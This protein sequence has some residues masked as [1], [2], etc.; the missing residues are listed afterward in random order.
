MSLPTVHESEMFPVPNGGNGRASQA[1]AQKSGMLTAFTRHKLLVFFMLVCGLGF[2]YLYFTRTPVLYESSTQILM[3]EQQLPMTHMS[4]GSNYENQLSTQMFIARSQKVLLLALG[5][6]KSAEEIDDGEQPDQA[7]GSDPSEPGSELGSETAAGATVENEYAGTDAPADDEEEISYDRMSSLETFHGLSDVEIIR[8]IIENTD[9]IAID[10][11][12]FQLTFTGPNRFDC[13]KVIQKITR[14]YQQF[15]EDEYASTG[16]QLL[17]L[18]QDS[19]ARSREELL[20]RQQAHRE[21]RETSALVPIGDSESINLHSQKLGQIVADQILVDGRIFELRTSIKSLEQFRDEEGSA[22]ALQLLMS[23]MP[24][25]SAIKEE[26]TNHGK[27]EQLQTQIEDL[28]FEDQQLNARLG[29]DHPTRTSLRDRINE[30]KRRLREAE[31]ISSGPPADRVAIWLETLEGHLQLETTRRD[32]LDERFEDERDGASDLEIEGLLDKQLLADIERAQNFY[33]SV[34]LQIDSLELTDDVDRV[35]T[36]IMAKPE[37]G[38]QVQPVFSTIMMTAGA[39]GIL[40]GLVIGYLLER[41]DA[42]FRT[43]DDVRDELKIPVMGH[44]PTFPDRIRLK[45]VETKMDKCLWAFHRPGGSVA[46]AFKGIRTSL[47]FNRHEENHQVLMITSP[48]PGEGKSTVAANLAISLAH[49]GKRVLLMDADLR[50]ST[51]P[52]L[53]GVLEEPGLTNVL[54]DDVEPFDVIQQTEVM[55]LSILAGGKNVRNPSELLSSPKMATLLTVLREQF[56]YVL[57]DTP[58]VLVVTDP[59]TVAPLADAVIGVLKLTRRTRR[60]ALATVERI[61]DVG[62]EVLGV[63]VNGLESGMGYGTGYGYGGYQYTDGYGYG[64]GRYYPHHEED[65]VHV[66][67][68]ARRITAS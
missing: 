61:I 21:F 50:R 8:F 35:T 3:I 68:Q 63:V 11:H 16:E 38:E 51:Q 47:Q 49:L 52:R 36:R 15:V 55:G 37:D 65:G 23:E 67:D 31:V 6:Q 10:D 54:K 39:L 41:A 30:Y 64:Y 40:V 48:S 17:G 4:S 7:F 59:L 14:A 13:R 18:L 25:S 45:N 9:A 29:V 32:A 1:Q 53:F 33:D 58:P 27:I 22:E 56:D 42:S 60:E 66:E 26:L 62:G 2:G 34:L 5:R 44:I 28:E 46:E 57:I 43:P 20:A 12:A 19:E 24:L